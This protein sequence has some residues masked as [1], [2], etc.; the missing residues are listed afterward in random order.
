M[1]GSTLLVSIQLLVSF[2]LGLLLNMS[3]ATLN[4]MLIF[5]AMQSLKSVHIYKHMC[6]QI[7]AYY[8]IL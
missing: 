4:F 2:L 5:G 1:Y 6:I 8:I 3:L 7:Y